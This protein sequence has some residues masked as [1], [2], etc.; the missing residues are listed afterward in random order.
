M[1]LSGNGSLPN[2]NFN[3]VFPLHSIF[4][5]YPVQTIP[6][7]IFFND[8]FPSLL[9]SSSFSLAFHFQF[10]HSLNVIFLFAP[11]N[12]VKALESFFLIR[13]KIGIT[14][15]FRLM[16]YFAFSFSFDVQASLSVDRSAEFSFHMN[17]FSANIPVKCQVSFLYSRAG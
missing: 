1:V 12:M 16:S 9:K 10:V 3:Q 2:S 17:F 5:V 6:F 8:V 14:L 13:S 4:C 11:A 7:K 15:A